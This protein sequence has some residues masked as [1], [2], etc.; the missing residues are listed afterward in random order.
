MA[1]RPEQG[2][3]SA[4]P[5]LRPFDPELLTICAPAAGRKSGLWQNSTLR[6]RKVERP[7]STA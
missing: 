1:T 4:L 7:Y 3:A 2:G 5:D 6:R